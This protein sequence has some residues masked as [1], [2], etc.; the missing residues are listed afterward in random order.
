M[1]IAKII[2]ICPPADLFICILSYQSHTLDIGHCRDK[3]LAAALMSCRS[4]P[5][6]LSETAY[7][8]NNGGYG[9]RLQ[10]LYH[11]TYHLTCHQNLSPMIKPCN[12]R[13]PFLAPTTKLSLGQC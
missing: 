6:I 3:G 7:R 2:F 12:F 13:P 9:F 8:R 5:A 10:V 11:L 4:Q 1:V